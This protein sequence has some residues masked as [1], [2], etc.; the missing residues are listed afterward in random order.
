MLLQV[1]GLKTY[2][3]TRR[4]AV[5]AVDGI[6][7]NVDNG[8]I[9]ALVGES[10][11]G[12][13]VSALSLLRLIPEPPGNISGEALFDGVDLLKMDKEEM[14]K[15]RGRRMAVVFQEPMTSLN[16]VFSIGRQLGEGML[17]HH[18]VDQKGIEEA[19]ISLMEKVGIPGGKHRLGQYPGQFSGGMRQRVMMAMALSCTPNLI[20]ADEP[21]TAVDV[22]IQ[23]QLLE[24]LGSVIKQ[25]G[26]AVLL[27]THNLGIVAKYANRVNVM[28][29]GRIVE[30]A[31][32]D[33][34]FYNPQHPYTKDLLGCVPRLDETE[35]TKLTTIQGQPP[36][37]I[38]RPPGCAYHPRC[39]QARPECEREWP[40][41]IPISDTHFVAC[42]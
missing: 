31:P 27:I 19:N 16:P 41:L 25:S 17:V 28:Y 15:I 8:E 20:I 38:D 6:S 10:G 3:D 42:C 23:A 26:S 37:L 4:G 33:E 39:S 30:Q 21:T 11:C 5:K 14:R 13:T 7:Y 40:Q 22:T 29:A 34:I 1:K 35:H 9:V 32:I 18:M 24:L 12:K 36:D 2:F